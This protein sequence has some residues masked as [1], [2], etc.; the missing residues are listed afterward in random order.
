MKR[1]FFNIRWR[2]AALMGGD[3]M[4]LG[5]LILLTAE[6]YLWF[7]GRYELS[8]Y[9]RLWPLLPIFV[10]VNNLF[11]MY[12]GD[13]LRA[14]APLGAAEELR[15]GTYSLGIVFLLLTAWLFVAKIGWQFSRVVLVASFLLAI[16]L[17]PVMRFAVRLILK[18]LGIGNL[19][20]VILG[21]GRAG[22]R[23]AA[24]C[25]GSLT[26]GLE[27]VAF[28][29]DDPKL[30]DTAPEG[31]PVLGPVAD[32]ESYLEREKIDYAVLALAAPSLRGAI[33]RFTVRARHLLVVPD[34]SFL[35]SM[36]VSARD[37][38]GVL[39]LELSCNLLEKRYL[40]TKNVFDWGTALVLTVV[41]SPV[42]LAIGIG[43]AISSGWPIL[44]RSKRLGRDGKHFP[45][46][47]FRSMCRNADARLAALLA[48]D[49]ALAAEWER[50]FKLKNDP[51]VTRFGAFLRKTSLDELPQLFNVLAGQMSLVGPRPIIDAEIPRFGRGYALRS[52]VR[53]G[54]TGMWQ[55]SG[56]SDVDYE[57][58]V[59]L[60][61]S[62]I[63]NWSLW[64]DYLILLRTVSA[65]VHCR[66][67][68]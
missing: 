36:G 56:R 11:G 44:Y 66:G 51:R 33:E 60:D 64:L 38:D 5:G 58:R 19:P 34:T 39:G 10:A 63:M 7:G 42:L 2:L 9:F 68:R 49:P 50:E 26:L 22:K 53:P 47:K 3:V 65:V 25:R 27:P 57:E 48:A 15:R 61:V 1:T 16:L 40:W 62:Y 30:R 41:L 24:L 43:V 23:I 21:A 67:A 8:N 18:K 55:V 37:L 59:E 46:L 14:G 4:L 28:F 17:L 31:V 45:I 13:L 35:C 52:R 12:H 54:I 20:V 32:A 29:D 6:V